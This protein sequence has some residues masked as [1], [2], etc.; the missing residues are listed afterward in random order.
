M[1]LLYSY[2]FCL[3]NNVCGYACQTPLC[4]HGC[5]GGQRD[6][7]PWVQAFGGA[8]RLPCPAAGPPGRMDVPLHSVQNTAG[9]GCQG[10]GPRT[11]AASTFASC[12][13]P[14]TMGQPLRKTGW[15]FL[16]SSKVHLAVTRFPSQES[17]QT[18]GNTPAE[19]R[20]ARRDGE[21]RGQ[22]P[23]EGARWSLRVWSTEGQGMQQNEAGDSQSWARGPRPHCGL[24]SEADGRLS[25]GVKQECMATQPD[26]FLK[27]R[28][29][30]GRQVCLRGAVSVCEN[31]QGAL[32]WGGGLADVSFAPPNP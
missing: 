8:A 13:W 21:G 26:F 22:G 18:N 12:W 25:P 24:C 15:Q 27:G 32:G 30:G 2:Q 20:P 14:C 31:S 29:A 1:K 5:Y 19:G 28:S 23:P 17:R 10:P 9:Q 3:R 11:D 7:R 4:L 16:I 6:Q